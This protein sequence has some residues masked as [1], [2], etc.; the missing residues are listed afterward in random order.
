[1][2]RLNMTGKGTKKL[3]FFGLAGIANY[4]TLTATKGKISNRV[5]IVHQAK[6]CVHFVTTFSGL[7]Q[8]QH[9]INLSGSGEMP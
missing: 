9:P 7:G 3:S 8:F 1:M 2:T 6:R 4:Q 5:L